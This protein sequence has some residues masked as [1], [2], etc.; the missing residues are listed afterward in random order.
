MTETYCHSDFEQKAVTENKENKHYN[1][2]ILKLT[3]ELD[4][5][6]PQLSEYD[7]NVFKERLNNKC[8]PSG[9]KQVELDNIKR[10]LSLFSQE[11][12][13]IVSIQNVENAIKWTHFRIAKHFEWTTNKK[14]LLI[15]QFHQDF[16]ASMW[17]KWNISQKSIKT[18]TSNFSEANLPHVIFW[19]WIWWWEW[20][21]MSPISGAQN[22]LMSINHR[23]KENW[24]H[25]NADWYSSPQED[26]T[27]QNERARVQSITA[28]SVTEKIVLDEELIPKERQKLVEN[29]L[30]RRKIPLVSASLQNKNK[31]SDNVTLTEQSIYWSQWIPYKEWYT[32]RTIHTNVEQIPTEDLK[33]EH[34]IYLMNV[35]GSKKNI[36]KYS[37]EEI[38]FILSL[39]AEYSILL[40]KELTINNESA[41]LSLWAKH[42]IEAI[43]SNLS[44]LGKESDEREFSTSN[45]ISR[46]LHEYNLKWGILVKWAEHFNRN[47]EGSSTTIQEELKKLRIW[48]IL[49]EATS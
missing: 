21:F 10:S 31:N 38:S 32:P 8:L 41:L 30:K 14:V 15:P 28:E 48:F 11:K 18:L 22:R 26:M 33:T 45:N 42:Q 6:K 24:I 7:Y 5:I 29:E 44:A 20:S 39:W 19:E 17:Q 1:K 43:D 13:K 35:R 16:E 23:D 27:N 49:L 9:L 3:E 40:K 37:E 25:I 2:E 47:A 4:T 36:T 46:F 12:N 34:I